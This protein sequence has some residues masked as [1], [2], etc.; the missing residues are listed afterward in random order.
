MGGGFAGAACAIHLARTS[1]DPLDIRIVEPRPEL[2]MGV[3][4]SAVE[5][6]LRLNGPTGIHAPY[7]DAPDDFTQ[8]M[9][10]SG[11]LARDPGAVAASGL[12]FARRGAFGRYM[13]REVE[14]HARSNPSG[15]RIEHVREQA[16]RATPSSSG[17]TVD[18]ADGHRLEAVHVV[19]APGW[20]EVGTP[21]ELA[22]IADDPGW[23]GNPW[24]TERFDTI[25][26]H[27]PVL[28][29]GSGLTASDTFASG[30]L[31]VTRRI[32]LRP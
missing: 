5:P 22:G 21:R 17:A 16:V 2:G 18:L 14:R 29:V 8:W 25:D 13:A 15:S 1:P 27:A 10:Q 19:L 20:N 28:L 31:D 30:I 32:A 12:V 26:R 9:E 6:D 11:E 24:L 4:H 23:H 3:A 7:P